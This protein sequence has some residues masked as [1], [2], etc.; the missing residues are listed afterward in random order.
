MPAQ[1]YTATITVPVPAADA[2][3]AIQDFRRWWSADI[4][5]E[6][7][8]VGETFFYHYKDIHLC[9]LKLIKAVLPTQL[10]YEVIENKFNFIEDQSEWVGTHLVFL[11]EERGEETTI[12][13]T[14]EG[15]V[16][17]YECYDVCQE[18]WSNYIQHSL[19]QLITTGTGEPNPHGEEGFNAELAE[20]WQINT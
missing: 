8:V 19:R 17:A 2:F 11:L 18:A 3:A 13:F 14:H 1:S 10:V 4:E 5:G 12:Q 16:P 7:N 15:L 9:K 20:K 6:T